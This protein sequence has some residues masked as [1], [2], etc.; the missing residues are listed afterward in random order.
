M[1]VSYCFLMRP[2]LRLGF[3]ATFKSY[4]SQDRIRV[5]DRL[6]EI[7]R[8]GVDVFIDCLS[9]H[10]G[11]K[12]KARLKREICDRDLFMLFWSNHARDSQWVEWEWRTALHY[13]GVD[14]IEPHPLD[15]I[16]E[17]EPPDELRDLH[18]C[19]RYRK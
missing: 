17:A 10:P 9:L 19:D 16:L 1:A 7:E 18:F 3:R 2:K 6:S 15:P 4:A 8:S 5:L 12:W 11:D 13:K 14:G